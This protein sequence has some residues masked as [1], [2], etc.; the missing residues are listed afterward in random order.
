MGTAK[1]LARPHI[2][3]HNGR[4]RLGFFTLGKQLYKWEE[5]PSSYVI[6]VVFVSY[7]IF[8]VFVLLS[9]LLQWQCKMKKIGRVR[10]GNF[11]VL[12]EEKQL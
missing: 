6:F 9:F 5:S 1:K 4:L 10:K 11:F 12:D 2:I 3:V 8:V 7:V